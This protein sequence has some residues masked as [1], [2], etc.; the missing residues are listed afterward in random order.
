MFF[1]EN[2]RILSRSNRNGK[3]NKFKINL[4]EYM[5]RKEYKETRENFDILEILTYLHRK[6]SAN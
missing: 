1:R 3:V 2:Q 6:I 4:V 5:Q